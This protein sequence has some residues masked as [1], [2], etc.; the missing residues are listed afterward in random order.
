MPTNYIDKIITTDNTEYVISVDLNNVQNADDLKAIEGISG[1]SG[2]LR[3]TASNTWTLDTSTYA[4]TSQIPTKTSDLTNDSGYITSE[5]IPEG[6]TAS[7][8]TPL[9]DG[10]ASV[11]SE[12]AFARGDHRHPTDTSRAPLASPAFTGTPTAPTAA[13]G[14]NTTQLATTAFVQSAL[15]SISGPMIFKGTLGT[16]GTITTLPAASSS[17]T[18][19]VYKVIVAGTYA[20]QAAKVG[21][22]FVSNGSSWILIPSGDD[23]TSVNSASGDVTL[24]NSS[25]TTGITVSDHSTTTIYGVGSTTTSVYGVKSGTNSTTTASKASGANGTAPT[26]GT[27][28]SV[29]NVTAAGSGSFTQGSFDGGS[30]TP[31]VDTSTHTLSFAFTPATHGAD[32]HTHTAPT[33]GTKFTIPNVTSAGSAST[34]SFSDVTVPIR[35][36]SATTV[37]IKDSSTT[38]VV[39]SKT[40][41]VTDNGHTHTINAQ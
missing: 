25:S 13:S 4:T 12:L 28:F 21:D 17:N 16:G 32:S 15:S 39:T 8:T 2:L 41:T 36:D 9:M 24:T 31:S 29:P 38:T 20:S 14:T 33:L 27:A 6:S 37:P 1:T 10:T 19:F 7:T 34:W 5:D 26:L 18:G 35:A 11:G 40:H 22:V 3:K 23:V 30:F